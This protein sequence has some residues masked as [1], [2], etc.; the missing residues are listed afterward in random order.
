MSNRRAA[1][2]CASPSAAP[3]PSSCCEIDGL[4]DRV[5]RRRLREVVSKLGKRWIRFVLRKTL[6][7]IG[8]AP[9]QSHSTWRAQFTVQ[10]LPYQRVHELKT[11]ARFLRLAD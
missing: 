2:S 6:D 9:M 4:V 8:D 7:G 11:T 5:S 1:S 3:I 10:R